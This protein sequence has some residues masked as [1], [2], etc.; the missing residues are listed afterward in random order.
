V[1]I[2]GADGYAVAEGC[3]RECLMQEAFG[4]QPDGLILAAALGCTRYFPFPFP[5]PLFPQPSPPHL[6]SNL[7]ARL[8]N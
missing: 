2:T 7:K 4:G 6:K 5:S 8:T 1:S 3:V